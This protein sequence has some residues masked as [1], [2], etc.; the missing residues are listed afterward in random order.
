MK[1]R[2]GYMDY[3]LGYWSEQ[4]AQEKDML[5]QINQKHGTIRVAPN[6]QP[7]QEACTILHEVLHGIVW[8]RV[9]ADD[10]QRGTGLEEKIVHQVSNGLITF[11]RDN[12]AFVRSLVDA[13]E[14]DT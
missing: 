2:I 11:I 5:G 10:L 4:L 14:G 7:H 13:M 8:D 6:Q 12:P 9:G 1:I 3:D